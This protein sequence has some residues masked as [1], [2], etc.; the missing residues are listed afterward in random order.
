VCIEETAKQPSW[1][2]LM[3]RF[4]EAVSSLCSSLE[5]AAVEDWEQAK[6]VPYRSAVGS[7]L[8]RFLIGSS[9]S[10]IL[11]DFESVEPP[12][13]MISRFVIRR[14]VSQNCFHNHSVDALD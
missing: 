1:V 4:E 11:F 5:T 9:M 14:E 10:A 6:H 3:C 8:K 2:D 13:R 7:Y 12:R